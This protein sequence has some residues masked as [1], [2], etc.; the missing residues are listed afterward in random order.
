MSEE[1]EIPSQLPEIVNPET[2]LNDSN[3]SP[4]E[5]Q[6]PNMEVHHHPDV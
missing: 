4:S 1:H 2:T 3:F 6:P 5:I